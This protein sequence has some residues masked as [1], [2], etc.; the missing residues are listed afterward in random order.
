M[1]PC[2]RRPCVRC[3]WTGWR[4]WSS[5]V[6]MAHASCAGTEW[7]SAPSA[8]RPSSAAS[9]STS[10]PGTSPL[11]TL[12]AYTTTW[13]CCASFVSQGRPH[14]SDSGHNSGFGCAHVEFTKQGK[15]MT[16]TLFKFWCS[17]RK[18][19]VTLLF[20]HLPPFA[21]LHHD[22]WTLF[23]STSWCLRLQTV[24]D[25]N[26]WAKAQVWISLWN[27]S[28]YQSEL[29]SQRRRSRPLH[30]LVPVCL[31]R[32]RL[33]QAGFTVFVKLYASV[34]VLEAPDVDFKYS[35][36]WQYGHDTLLLRWVL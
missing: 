10:S 17:A 21:C 34:L 28:D 1:S 8:A 11:Q 14:M 12:K 29:K 33:L 13:A 3:V 5:C 26:L 16:F 25:M 31:S 20:S 2:V 6:A 32:P 7:A 27:S 15:P 19:S 36:S 23:S 4:T 22:T 30:F 24:L 18:I 35:L 9:S